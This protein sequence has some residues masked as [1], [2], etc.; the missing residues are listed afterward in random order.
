M[1]WKQKGREGEKGTRERKKGDGDKRGGLRQNMT[2]V[3]YIFAV[4]FIKS[5]LCTINMC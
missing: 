4:V 3:H 2:K 1:T 5:S